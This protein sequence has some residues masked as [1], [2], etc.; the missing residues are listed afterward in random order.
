MYRA[1]YKG[2]SDYDWKSRRDQLGRREYNINSD[3][4][5]TVWVVVDSIHLGQNGGK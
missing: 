1:E 5:E 3:L 4:K 2:I